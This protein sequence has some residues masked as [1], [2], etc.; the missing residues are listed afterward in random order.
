M[1]EKQ[2]EYYAHPVRNIWRTWYR[3]K[4][5]GLGEAADPAMELLADYARALDVHG[6]AHVYDAL[7]HDHKW[8][9]NGYDRYGYPLEWC[10]ENTCAKARYL[11]EMGLIESEPSDDPNDLGYYVTLTV[12]G[13]KKLRQLNTINN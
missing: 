11:E 1:T 2:E 4:R 9:T 5:M 12:A 10:Q 3:R 13:M 8:W 7:D 6:W